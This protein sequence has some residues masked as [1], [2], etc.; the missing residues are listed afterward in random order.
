[1][2]TYIFGAVYWAP[3]QTECLLHSNRE[4]ALSSF[5]LPS[6]CSATCHIYSNRR[7]GYVC[8]QPLC[9]AAFVCGWLLIER[10]LL[11][12][13]C[14]PSR[15]TEWTLTRFPTWRIW[16]NCAIPKLKK[17]ELRLSALLS[18]SPL[19]QI[20]EVAVLSWPNVSEMFFWSCFSAKVWT[21]L[22]LLFSTLSPDKTPFLT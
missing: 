14:A 3:K 15:S 18:R 21:R 4:S 7:H 19:L 8:Y 10:Y 1:M 11:F 5:Q 6:K 9:D 2:T 22:S 12:S 13:C 20:V 17:R 16:M